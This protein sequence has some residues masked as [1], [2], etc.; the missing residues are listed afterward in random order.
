VAGNSNDMKGALAPT[1]PRASLVFV[2]NSDT[3]TSRDG[4]DLIL[5]LPRQ[6]QGLSLNAVAVRCWELMDGR[7]SLRSIA[8]RVA[9]EH[10]VPV[11]AALREVRMLAGRLR[12]GWYALPRG[13]WRVTHVH[14]GEPF[15]TVDDPRIV[16]EPLGEGLFVHRACDAGPIDEAHRLDD[17]PAW[18]SLWRLLISWPRRRRAER[19]FAQHEKHEASLRDATA[20]FERGWRACAAGRLPEAE[21]EFT[22]ATRLAPSWVNPRYQLGYVCL[23]LRRYAEAVRWFSRTEE[24]SPGFFMVRE[25]LGLARRL[26]AGALR[27]EAF[28]LFD[29][30]ASVE[31]SDPDTIIDLCRRA[32]ALSP[33]FPSARVVLGRAYA[34]KRQYERALD[35]LHR[36]IATGPDPA[37]LCHAL[38]AR[39]SIFMARGMSEQALREFEKV[40]Q[41]DGSPVAT[42]HVLDHL[43]SSGSVH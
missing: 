8:R 5:S 33:D 23:R 17:A 22:E 40:I 38:F 11:A 14:F 36:A 16:V 7:S 37:T 15:D 34:R 20:A 30:A 43:A 12:R 35:E 31:A 9:A 26:E 24:V 3:R 25:Y 10:Q 6:R 27:P 18:R 32:L 19:S 1:L 39:G 4:D 28:L 41:I 13:A 42:R 2:R 21:R 29:R